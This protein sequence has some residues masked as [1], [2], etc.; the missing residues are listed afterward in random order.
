[1]KGKQLKTNINLVLK[2]MVVYMVNGI[3]TI[4]HI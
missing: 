4:D 2:Q 3:E 1:L